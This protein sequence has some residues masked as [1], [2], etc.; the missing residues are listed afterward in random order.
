[1]VLFKRKEKGEGQ[2]DRERDRGTESG[3]HD[4]PA[5]T[6]CGIG[7]V[8]WMS[9][10]K[11]RREPQPLRGRCPPLCT[12]P[13]PMP[14][15]AGRAAGQSQLVTC[16]G[17]V[18]PGGN[19]VGTRRAAALFLLSRGQGEAPASS[20]IGFR[21]CPGCPQAP[22]TVPLALRSTR[23]THR[24][25]RRAAPAP[26]GRPPRFPGPCLS[27]ECARKPHFPWPHSQGATWCLRSWS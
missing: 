8:T 5:G 25:D 20:G 2:R 12:G 15:A 1:M 18:R 4:V 7:S 17:E 26:R 3:A 21:P 11:T 19:G 27:S 10:I 22:P 6:A 23:W 24:L 14:P 16:T 13:S 9:C